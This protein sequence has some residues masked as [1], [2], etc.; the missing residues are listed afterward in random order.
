MIKLTGAELPK[1][2]EEL[3]G[4]MVKRAIVCGIRGISIDPK[5]F[6][7]MH[8]ELAEQLTELTD[9]QRDSIVIVTNGMHYDIYGNPSTVK[10]QEEL[11]IVMIDEMNIPTEYDLREP[12]YHDRQKELRFLN[13][14]GKRR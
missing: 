6:A 10:V 4:E 7:E 9:E 11:G 1:E 14:R 13:K 2:T 5:R 12:T 8:K 3:E